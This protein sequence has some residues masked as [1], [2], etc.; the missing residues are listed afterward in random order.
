MTVAA[1]AAESMVAAMA[2]SMEA[3]M[4][5]SMAARADLGASAA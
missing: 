5:A 1:R 3:L 4:A 2:A